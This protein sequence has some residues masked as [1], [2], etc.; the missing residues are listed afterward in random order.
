M[1][2]CVL[3]APLQDKMVKKGTPPG[4]GHI[5]FKMKYYNTAEE[6]YAEH[7]DDPDIP[8]IVV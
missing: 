4:Q 3:G 5:Y 2:V 7:K 1:C 8:C 6:F